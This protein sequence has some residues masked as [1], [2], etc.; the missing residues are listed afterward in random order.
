[1]YLASP[2]NHRRPLRWST[3]NANALAHSPGAILFAL[4]A[5]P[6]SDATAQG[7]SARTADQIGARPARQ[8]R[9]AK[10]VKVATG[11]RRVISYLVKPLSDQIT[12]AFR[13]K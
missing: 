7:I 10:V 3:T 1:M 6:S 9:E 2:Q 8:Y 11:D 5:I 12:R 4:A 13:E